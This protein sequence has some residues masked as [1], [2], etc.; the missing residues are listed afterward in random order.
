[1]QQAFD[2]RSFG[3]ALRRREAAALPGTPCGETLRVAVTRL[4]RAAADSEPYRGEMR[5][6]ALKVLD[7]LDGA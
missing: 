7:K 4:R 3:L 1:V 5:R 6:S 2:L